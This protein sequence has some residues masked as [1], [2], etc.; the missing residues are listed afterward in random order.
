MKRKWWLVVASIIAA[1]GISLCF[2]GVR[3]RIAPR[4]VLYGAINDAFEQVESRFEN[5]PSHM[6][7]DVY[8]PEGQYQADLQLETKMAL[9]GLVRY[10]MDM[11]VQLQ[12]RRIQGSGTVVAG[13]KA[14]DLSVYMDGDFAA[15][16]SD[17]LVKGKY[18]G[19]CYDT[20]PQDLQDRDVLSLLIG[21]ETKAKWENS[22]SSLDEFLSKEAKLPKFSQSDIQA[23][24]YAVLTLDPQVSREKIQL[25]GENV[26]VHAITF[27]ASGQQ[28]AKAA[29]PYQ[30]ELTPQLIDWIE[31]IKNDPEFYVEAVFYLDHG[32]LVQLEGNLVSSAYSYRIS[33]CLGAPD[34]KQALSLDLEIAEGEERKRFELSV[35]NAEH[36][37][38]Y[39]E[40]I[41]FIHTKNGLRKTY[42][43]DYTYD[44][45]S[46]EMDLKL[47]K[48][49]EESQMRMHMAGEGE[50]LTITTQ[51]IAP[52]ISLFREKPIKIPMICTV[53]IMQGQ[54]ITA[55]EYRNLDQWSLEDLWI[56]IKGLGGL[57]GIKLW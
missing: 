35:E 33:A 36:E 41:S 10:D 55:P 15:V 46:G 42:G 14:L 52:L 4:L 49:A 45:N 7:L 8:D 56:L 44:L 51:D 39:Q 12:P 21:D 20:F 26:K 1:L 37:E 50:R 27:R 53:S 17:S 11:Q 3:V 32:T 5:S 25:S 24:L 23:A 57:I 6:L 9:V 30:Q 43:I 31:E 48:D 38:S 2:F 34:E 47:T 54:E 13:K 28:I 16:S 18:Y 22:V 40:K 19:I 29:K